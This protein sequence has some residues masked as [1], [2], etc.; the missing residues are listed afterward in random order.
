MILLLLLLGVV[1]AD[2]SHNSSGTTMEFI[3]N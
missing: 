3:Y 2:V 1:Y